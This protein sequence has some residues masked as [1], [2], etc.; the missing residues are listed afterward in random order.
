MQKRDVLCWRHFHRNAAL[1]DRRK[2][3][4]RLRRARLRTRVFL[5]GVDGG[6]FL[7]TRAKTV[8]QDRLY[9][10][11][12]GRGRYSRRQMKS[13]ETTTQKIVESRSE[14][15]TSH[16]TAELFNRTW[17]YRMLKSLQQWVALIAVVATT[18]W[19]SNSRFGVNAG[20]F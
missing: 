3:E 7:C 18:V 17:L 19:G 6:F 9:G 11:S 2:T 14:S 8:A 15:E 10:P 20:L 16:K 13:E 12:I 1:S 5:R 4:G